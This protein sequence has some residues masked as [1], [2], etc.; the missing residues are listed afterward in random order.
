MEPANYIYTCLRI[1][2]MRVSC[3][4]IL[5]CCKKIVRCNDLNK[6]NNSPVYR[7]LHKDQM[8]GIMENQIRNR[9]IT[10]CS[11]PGV[12]CLPGGM[13]PELVSVTEFLNEYIWGN[14]SA[15]ISLAGFRLL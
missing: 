14:S 15:G 2:Y 4:L 6:W 3:L 9:Q 10:A 12:K 5:N 13:N 1:R 11:G 7:Y 8:I